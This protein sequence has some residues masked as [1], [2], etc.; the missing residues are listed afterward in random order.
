LLYFADF[1]YYELYEEH[2]TG[3][4]Y[5][6]LPYGPVPQK[7]DAIINQMIDAG[8]L[9]RLKTDY[10]GLQQT[11]YLPLIK[12]NLSEPNAGEKEVIVLYQPAGIGVP[13]Q[14]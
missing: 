10:Y 3:A 5:R 13:P 9:K 6:K 14:N 1:N 2:L 8:Q 12:A 11:R 7:L 4:R